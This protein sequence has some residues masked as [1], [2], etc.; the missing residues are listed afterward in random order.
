MSSDAIAAALAMPLPGE[1]NTTFKLDVPV[2]L[3]GTGR[4]MRLV[5][6]DGRAVTASKPDPSL[7]KL[8]VEARAWWAELAKG[9]V[10]ITTLAQSEGVTAS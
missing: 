10:G 9:K 5:H 4:A 6:T 7:I 3:T 1:P 8:L 2:R